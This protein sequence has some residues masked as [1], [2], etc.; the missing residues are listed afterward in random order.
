[1]FVTFLGILGMAAGLASYL[2]RTHRALCFTVSVALLL[3][4]AHYLLLG[5]VT[6]AVLNG[7]SAARWSTAA[8]VIQQPRHV[9]WICTAIALA[10]VHLLTGLTW[11]GWSSFFPY[12]GN[13]LV[14]LASYHLVDRQFRIALLGG[15]LLWAATAIA[16][17]SAPGLALAIAGLALNGWMLR[18]SFP[19]APR[20]AA[21]IA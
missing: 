3:L 2:A 21:A 20:P 1:M 11:Q 19:A 16:A 10:V 8:W 13:V 18:S 9:R 17:G 4:G 15:E 14:V 5:A 6:A 7:F 12:A